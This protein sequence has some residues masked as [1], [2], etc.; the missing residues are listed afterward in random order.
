MHFGLSEEQVL[1]QDMLRRCL[2]AR[3]QMESLKQSLGKP[4]GADLWQAIVELGVTGA[5]IPEQYGGSGLRMLDA[6]IIAENMGRFVA[7]VPYLGS[8]L[9]AP[10]AWQL[11]GSPAQCEE[12]LGAIA[13]GEHRYGVGLTEAANPTGRAGAL[14]LDG[15]R[16]SGR[17]H[18]VLDALDATHYLLTAGGDTLVV[19]ER[20]ADGLTIEPLTSVDRTRGF[21]VLR[22]ERTPVELLGKA[23]TVAPAIQALI[24]AGRLALAA[25]TFGAAEVMFDRAR[26]YALERFQFDRPIASFQGVKH[27]LADMITELEPCRS[28]LWYTAHAFDTEPEASVLHACLAKSLTSDIG[29]FVARSS[30]EIHGGMGF[31]EVLGLH[32][33]Y[34]RIEANRQLL[35][36]PEVVRRD[37]A[38]A[39]GWVEPLVAGNV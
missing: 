29:K 24:A 26:T 23:G 2:E 18:F 4:C 11:A 27:L 28:L 19:V 35:G 1:L 32:L 31:T 5:L 20:N 30:I 21:A 22:L 16:A 12:R 10:L 8:A 14:R 25:D 34:K 7:P 39:Q 17:C 9:L 33:W 37:A 6:E 36:G 15:A 38:L 3:L 13:Q